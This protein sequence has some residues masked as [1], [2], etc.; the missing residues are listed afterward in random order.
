MNR[1][2]KG[3]CCSRTGIHWLLNIDS[4]ALLISQ[5]IIFRNEQTMSLLPRHLRVALTTTCNTRSLVTQTVTMDTI[6]I[7]AIAL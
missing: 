7:T 5:Y 2:L 3:P 4:N 1:T 6:D